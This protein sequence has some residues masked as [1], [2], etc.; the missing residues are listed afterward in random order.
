MK[1]PESLCML[2]IQYAYHSISFIPPL[3]YEGPVVSFSEW[4]NFILQ[5]RLSETTSEISAFLPEE[6]VNFSCENQEGVKH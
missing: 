6:K 2:P 1:T 4:L 5:N 3:D